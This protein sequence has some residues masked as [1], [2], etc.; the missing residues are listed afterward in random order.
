MDIIS[1][2]RANSTTSDIVIASYGST[3]T[4]LAGVIHLQL[5]LSCQ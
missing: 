3:S 5:E 2:T 4:N 1:S